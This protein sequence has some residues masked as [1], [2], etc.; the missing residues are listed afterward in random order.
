MTDGASLKEAVE[1]AKSYLRKKENP[2]ITYLLGELYWRITFYADTEE[3]RKETFQKAISILEELLETNPDGFTRAR[4]NLLLSTVVQDN[5]YYETG[6]R[7]RELTETSIFYGKKA[8]EISRNLGNRVLE[9]HTRSSLAIAYLHLS[10]MEES[11]ERKMKSIEELITQCQTAVELF[12]EE[13]D[14]AGLA[15]CLMNLGVGM[16]RRYWFAEDESSREKLAA[17]YLELVQRALEHSKQTK[18]RILR[19]WVYSNLAAA[20]V[21]LGWHRKEERRRLMEK[22]LE[23]IE[24]GITE[25][26]SSSYMKGLGWSNYQAGRICVEMSK[27]LKEERWMRKAL[28]YLEKAVKYL[29]K[30]GDRN[31]LADCHALKGQVLSALNEVEE[32]VADFEK[33]AREYYN[34][35]WWRNAG[36]CYIDAGKLLLSI[37]MYDGATENFEQA[38]HCFN[39]GLG[40]E[41]GLRST[42]YEYMAFVE[43]LNEIVKAKR[44]HENHN[45]EVAAKAYEKAAEILCA[46]DMAEMECQLYRIRSNIERIEHSWENGNWDQ[47][48]VCLEEVSDTAHRVYEDAE[49]NCLDRNYYCVVLENS[50]TVQDFCSIHRLLKRAIELIDRGDLVSCSDVLARVSER[51]GTLNT[52]YGPDLANLYMGAHHLASIVAGNGDKLVAFCLESFGKIKDEEMLKLVEPVVVKVKEHCMQKDDIVYLL[53]ESFMSAELD[54]IIEIKL[55]PGYLGREP[56]LLAE[57]YLDFM[58]EGSTAKILV[59]N[60]SKEH[61]LTILRIEGGEMEGPVLVDA[62][63][64]QEISIRLDS[65]HPKIFY[66]TER[67]T[68]TK[69]LELAPIE[70]GIIG[71]LY[72]NQET[73]LRELGRIRDDQRRLRMLELDEKRVIEELNNSLKPGVEVEVALDLYFLKIG[74]RYKVDKPEIKGF[75]KKRWGAISNILG[76]ERSDALEDALMSRG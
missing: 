18:D 17:E 15:T 73:I 70:A 61:P 75:L 40:E 12:R 24:K 43:V 25:F 32:A 13:D 10:Y 57:A 59:Q 45:H 23:T 33:A 38:R 72:R 31:Q 42:L 51:C 7:K 47:F 16:K 37:S 52:D 9:G 27:L 41:R 26:E 39:R 29:D 46:M 5:S 54:P 4:V 30:T 64:T 56:D 62:N 22:A 76:K 34:F 44:Y 35:G 49:E 71:G 21:M 68:G 69:T 2:G 60:P 48:E 1:Y 11:R 19:G 20:N 74:R 8:L 28:E 55:G 63:S 50:K 65:P 14:H 58:G 3:N 53:K 6:E 67:G 66:M 36:E